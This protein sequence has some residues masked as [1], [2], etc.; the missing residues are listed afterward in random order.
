[1]QNGGNMEGTMHI[2][3]RM[4]RALH[5]FHKMPRMLQIEGLYTAFDW[6]HD[7]DYIFRGETHNFSELILVKSGKIRVTAG[8]RT[9][10]LNEGTAILHPPM[11]FH[12]L[13]SEAGSHEIILF[14]FFASRLPR[15]S[16][17]IFSVSPA[18]MATAE[19][20]LTLLQASTDMVHIFAGDVIS[21]H[22]TEAQC[23]ILELEL[24]LLSL[25]ANTET[26][27]GGDMSPRLSHYQLALS[28][29]EEHLRSPLDTA[30]IAAM[31]NISPSYLK[32]LFAHY[33]GMGVMEYVRQQKIH[34]AI[35]LL[36]EGQSVQSVALQLG[37]TDASYFSTVFRRITGLCP[38]AYQAH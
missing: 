20:I 31:C 7:A 23:A 2:S 22:E 35:A 25:S 19:R 32:K 17:H 34:A 1:M 10:V 15:F 36:H 8:S 3:G 18:Q 16:G 37:F 14:T 24:L 12:S 5:V 29:I 21:G 13:R 27:T 4:E 30:T 38:R 9:F 11:E 6:V 28:V 33:A 26:Q